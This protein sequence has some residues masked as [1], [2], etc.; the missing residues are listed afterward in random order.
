M[1]DNTNTSFESSIMLTKYT[2]CN[3]TISLTQ[4]M[5]QLSFFGLYF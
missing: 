3:Q 2:M 5:T 4:N 1:N